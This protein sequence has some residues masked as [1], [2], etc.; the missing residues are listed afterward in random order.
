MPG[1]KRKAP[2]LQAADVTKSKRTPGH[3]RKSVVEEIPGMSTNSPTPNS[4]VPPH[5]DLP[6]TVTG[7]QSGTICSPSYNLDCP[8][9]ID[10]HAISTLTCNVSENLKSKIINSDYIELA[11]LLENTS[12][13]EVSEKKIFFT[14]KGEL[15]TK[16]T[17]RSNLKINS[18]SKWTDAFLIF[19][20]IYSVAHPDSVQGLF[21]YIHDIRLGAARCGNGTMGWKK[22]DEQ[23][24]LRRRSDPSMPWSKI[25]YELWLLF[26]QAPQQPTVP[27]TSLSPYAHNKCFNFN[28]RGRCD[29]FNC[30]YVHKCIKCSGGHPQC[31]CSQLNTASQT[32]NLGSTFNFRPIGKFQPRYKAPTPSYPQNFQSV[33]PQKYLGPRSNAY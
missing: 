21:K 29:R 5:I 15:I 31:A 18:I 3:Q 14:E 1:R 16:E 28:Y 2:T 7:Q 26:M 23:F 4:A 17:T 11:L 9:P 8:V 33:R 32:P 6:S 13:Q 20:S 25:D 10:S 27:E 19:A 12:L 22:Y 24:R 30:R